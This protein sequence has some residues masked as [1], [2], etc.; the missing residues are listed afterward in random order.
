V[1][2]VHCFPS[3]LAVV[4]SSVSAV[5]MQN[6]TEKEE[7]IFTAWQPRNRKTLREVQDK[8]ESSRI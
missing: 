2:R 4:A 8:R 7:K 3:P 5:V 1:V 6:I